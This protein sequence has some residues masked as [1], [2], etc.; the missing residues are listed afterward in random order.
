MPNIATSLTD[1]LVKYLYILCC[2]LSFSIACNA[3]L[4]IGI[5]A[6]TGV[7]FTSNSNYYT[8][9]WGMSKIQTLVA[10]GPMYA[11]QFVVSY[12]RPHWWVE[13][14]IGVLRSHESHTLKDPFIQGDYKN[15]QLPND[16]IN[17]PLK[18]GFPLGHIRNVTF[19]P[20]IGLN[21]LAENMTSR[22]AGYDRE[23]D[24]EVKKGSAYHGSYTLI[25]NDYN[26]SAT[27][28]NFGIRAAIKSSKRSEIIVGFETNLG[29]R[30][31][32]NNILEMKEYRE[33]GYV[34]NLNSYGLTKGDA[35]CVS[36]GYRFKL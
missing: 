10:A 36:L 23:V 12:R 34:V 24:L 29:F 18:I 9:S 28:L 3:Q 20:H 25:P 35:V 21:I 13:A 26:I 33:G 14:G 4:Q 22:H 6:Q 27:L 7:S 11:G 32:S 1:T 30:S 17:V 31:L 16:F 19:S 15:V 2:V 8:G 5:D